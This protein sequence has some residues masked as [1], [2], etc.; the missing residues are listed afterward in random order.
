MQSEKPYTKSENVISRFSL[1]H[2]EERPSI[3]KKTI[4][5]KAQFYTEIWHSKGQS[6]K[7]PGLKKKSLKFFFRDIQKIISVGSYNYVRLQ[8][9]IGF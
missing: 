7:K 5:S 1:H 9:S 3:L 8:M 4:V 6:C 2:I